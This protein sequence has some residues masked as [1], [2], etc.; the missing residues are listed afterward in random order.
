[1]F[2]FHLFKELAFSL[3]RISIIICQKKSNANVDWSAVDSI[4][5]SKRMTSPFLSFLD[6]C[7]MK[8]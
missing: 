8:Y 1:M 4:L 2:G 6:V 7:H 5:I 3:D